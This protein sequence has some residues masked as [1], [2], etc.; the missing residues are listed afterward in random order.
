MS[1]IKK[2]LTEK[3]GFVIEFSVSK[4]VYEKAEME[5]K[6]W[7]S[8]NLSQ[9]LAASMGLSEEELFQVF[10]VKDAAEF[11]AKWESA[12]RAND[13]A[14]LSAGEFL[15]SSVENAFNNLDTSSLT[16]E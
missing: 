10:G 11:A 6:G 9:N 2:E 16:A 7:T 3:S 13:N 15:T 14:L 5:A 4:E 8:D 12:F 1:L